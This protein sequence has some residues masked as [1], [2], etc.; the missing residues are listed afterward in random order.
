MSQTHPI[1]Y[2]IKSGSP[3]TSE[4]DLELKDGFEKGLNIIQLGEAHKRTPGGISARLKVLELIPNTR[5]V[6]GYAE[7]RESELYKEITEVSS[8]KKKPAFYA[9]HSSEKSGIYTTWS[10]ANQYIKG[11][12]GVKHKKFSDIQS[13]N[14]WL[15]SHQ[16]SLIVNTESEK[17]IHIS[18]SNLFPGVK[19]Y[20]NESDEP[21]EQEPNPS[22]PLSSLKDSLNA[23]QLE[24]L[25]K[26]LQGESIFLTGPGGSGKSYLL[27]SVKQEFQRIGKSL[28][29]T[30]LTGC[31]ALLL[32]SNAKTLHSWAGIGLGKGDINAIISSIVMNGRKKKAWLKTDCIVIDEVSMMT[33]QLLELLDSV[34]RRVRKCH[35]KPMGGLQ[36]I[37]V[38]DFYQ[39]PPVTTDKTPFAFQ[40]PLW[41]EIITS[42]ISLKRIYRQSDEMF[43]KVL[44]EARTGTLSDE[45][46][47]ILKGRMNLPWKKQVIR[48]TL[49]FTR[50]ADVNTINS[51]HFAK[52][53]GECKT[54]KVRTI[55]PSEPAAGTL[56]KFLKTTTKTIHGLTSEEIQWKVEHLDKDAPYE[57]ELCLK[58]GAQVM[59]ITNLNQEAGLINGSRGV[60]KG[61]DGD[62]L[63]LVLFASTNS[64]SVVKLHKWKAEGD[65]PIE[66]EQI[67][68]RLAY[69]LTIHKAQGASLDSAFIDIGSSTFEYGQAYVALSRVRSLEALFIYDLD[70][71]A[72]KVHPAV[73]AFY[74]SLA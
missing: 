59:L 25:N 41:N 49:L 20:K 28:A 70:P 71:K 58:V 22:T 5:K 44:G 10:E 8:F 38:G 61:F 52:L 6:L 74:D 32:G 23:E 62:G 21:V 50:N 19:T 63:P 37:F 48:P 11:I 67:P 26:I 57:K 45:S 55:L 7:Y 14:E 42:T 36:I 18:S 13:A 33:P 17:K 43:Q 35:D 15:Q 16:P 24:A 53:D 54:Y 56:D 34:G 1:A 39:L 31:A 27:E 3:W 72:F 29:I 69:A 47:E 4:E 66:R 30:A 51:S 60:V 40:S 2:Y 65:V 64:T 12:S 9:V 73:K 46:I 68:L